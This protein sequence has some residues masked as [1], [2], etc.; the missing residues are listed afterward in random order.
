MCHILHFVLLRKISK[1]SVHLLRRRRAKETDGWLDR[2]IPTYP[3]KNV[4]CRGYKNKKNKKSGIFESMNIYLGPILAGI[5]PP[6][7]C[8]QPSLQSSSPSFSSASPWTFHL[9][10]YQHFVDCLQGQVALMKR[11]GKT[12]ASLDQQVRP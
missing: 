7:L 4:V 8:Q 12:L 3:T 1:V 9:C 10:P 5:D 6:I 11:V 2:V